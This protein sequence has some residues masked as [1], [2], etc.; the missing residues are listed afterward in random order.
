MKKLN[1]GINREVEE[2]VDLAERL[3]KDSRIQQLLKEQNDDGTAVRN[4]PW[5]FS[6]YLDS[7]D[8][9]Y[10]KYGNMNILNS[11]DRLYKKIVITDHQPRLVIGRSE[12]QKKEDKNNAFRRNYLI[13]DLPEEA[14][15]YDIDK[16][17]LMNESDNYRQ[18]HAIVRKWLTELPDKG[19]YLV[20]GLGVGKSYLA[21]CM[22]NYLAKR[23]H[24]VS[25]VNVPGF[26]SS[27]R[28]SISLNDRSNF[29]NDSVYRL[30][31]SDFLV[32]DDIGA[33]NVTNWVRDD[34][35]FPVLEYRMVNRKSTIFTSNSNLADLRERLA[36]SNGVRDYMKAD[37]IIERIRTLS[38]E[39]RLD[40]NSRRK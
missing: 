39:V 20:G 26:M 22:T 17:N 27:A 15:D 35:L 25:F 37:R 10:D 34:I 13:S 21:A 24:K 16:I 8:N 31:R 9:G 38:I 5:V 36:Y 18:V 1:F 23:N 2:T 19:L 6:D 14:Y 28:N 30:K 33:E 29:I 4:D 11:S 40:G 7:L 32:L 3:L 12:W